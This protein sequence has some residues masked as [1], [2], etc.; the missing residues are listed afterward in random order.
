M[1]GETARTDHFMRD[2]GQGCGAVDTKELE[3]LD[4]WMIEIWL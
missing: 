4:C 2:N 3:T 1:V